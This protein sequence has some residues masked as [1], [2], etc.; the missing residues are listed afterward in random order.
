MNAPLNIGTTPLITADF[1]SVLHD[2]SNHLHVAA[3]PALFFGRCRISADGTAQGVTQGVAQ[4]ANGMIVVLLSGRLTI[5]GCLLEGRQRIAAIGPGRTISWQASEGCEVA[6]ISDARLRHAQG[7][8]VIDADCA[9]Q[10]SAAPDPSVLLTAPPWCAAAQH[11][12]SP[13][14]S[15]GI[16]SATPYTRRHVPSAVSE[17]MLLLNG[18]VA[19]SSKDGLVTKF[20]EGAFL[21]VPQDAELDWSSAQNVR[22][23]YYSA[24]R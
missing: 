5:G 6:L 17:F 13:S 20:D 14:V 9:L 21:L 8:M 11:Y 24:R 2:P 12:K 4:A 23:F 10:P 22:K 3:D 1:G 16:W 19:L 7:A 18:S 15:Y